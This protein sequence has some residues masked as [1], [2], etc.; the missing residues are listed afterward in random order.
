MTPVKLLGIDGFHLHLGPC[1]LVDGTPVFDIKP[2]IPA[3]DAFPEESAGWLDE[4]DAWMRQDPSYQVEYAPLA[5]SQ[6]AWLKTD[7]GID[8]VERM[9]EILNRDPM[10]HRTRRIRSKGDGLFEIGCGAWRARYRLRGSIVFI[11]NIRSGFPIDLLQRF[12]SEEIPDRDAQL[13]FLAMWSA[14]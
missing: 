2:Y 1:D 14:L 11:E 12:H 9:E 13:A 8:F 5:L 10:P 3:Y 6:L 4:V 7:W